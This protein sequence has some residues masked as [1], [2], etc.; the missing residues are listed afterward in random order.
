MTLPQMLSAIVGVLIV[1]SAGSV[2]VWQRTRRF[3]AL[4]WMAIGAAMTFAGFQP[5]VIEYLGEDSVELRLRLVVAL[6][7]FIVLTI[8]FEAIRVGRMQERYAFL[9]LVTGLIL[10][11]GAVFEDLA[12]LVRR[13]TGISFGATVILILFAFVML[14]LFYLSLAIS[15]LQMNV[16]QLTRELAIAEERLR[17]LERPPDKDRSRP[18][19]EG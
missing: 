7:S 4:F 13:L 15:S 12:S 3:K 19:K 17:R 16:S 1:I 9:W 18:Q 6:L 5:Q 10:L 14:L 8:T 11:L 2:F